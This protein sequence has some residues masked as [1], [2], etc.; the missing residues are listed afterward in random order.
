METEK[1][2]HETRPVEAR[3]R[4]RIVF[5]ALALFT[6]LEFAVSVWLG[7]LLPALA[8]IALVKAAL[9]IIYF[10]HVGE[11]GAIWRQEV[12]E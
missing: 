2:I 12:S 4:G 5:G 3:R 6:A 11:L 1:E 8:L 10:M 7:G 9:I